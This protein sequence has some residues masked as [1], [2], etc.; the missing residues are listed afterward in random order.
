MKSSVPAV[1]VLAGVLVFAAAC[2][3][4]S[5]DSAGKRPLEDQQQA[6]ERARSVEEDLAESARARGRA[7][8]GEDADG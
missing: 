1:F 3:D 8:D 6:L 7:A 2:T 5:G 4:D